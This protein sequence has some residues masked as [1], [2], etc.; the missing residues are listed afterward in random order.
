MSAPYRFSRKRSMLLALFWYARANW[1]RFLVTSSNAR[2]SCFGAADI[3]EWILPARE[4][5]S[6]NGKTQKSARDYA[7]FPFFIQPK[8]VKLS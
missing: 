4:H 6:E 8:T 1:T 2:S 3:T 5:H 7:F